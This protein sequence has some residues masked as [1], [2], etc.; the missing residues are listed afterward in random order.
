VCDAEP[1]KFN[2]ALNN[3]KNLQ[4]DLGATNIEREIVTYKSTTYA[5]RDRFS[6]GVRAATARSPLDKPWDTTEKIHA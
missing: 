1:A 4:E 2:S 5:T 3:A 6:S